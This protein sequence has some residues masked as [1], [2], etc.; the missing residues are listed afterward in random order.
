MPKDC[1]FLI[2]CGVLEHYINGAIYPKGGPH[3]I[4]ESLVG[5]I[6]AYGGQVLT[7]AT[8]NNILVEAGRAVGVDCCK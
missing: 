8:V 7:K 5:T 1:P 2:H 4:V 6:R 3:K